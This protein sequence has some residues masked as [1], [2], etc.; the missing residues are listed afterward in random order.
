[1]KA[2]IRQTPS[3]RQPEKRP[4]KAVGVSKATL[5][6]ATQKSISLVKVVGLTMR[7]QEQNNHLQGLYAE[8]GK[9]VY[10]QQT[11]KKVNVKKPR[12]LETTARVEKIA[13]IRKTM[14]RL[15]REIKALR[16]AA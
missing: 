15:E 4:A 16:K 5:V 6:D 8:L 9:L 3:S 2:Y 14:H 12:S 1:M 13:E 11:R 10:E 7:W